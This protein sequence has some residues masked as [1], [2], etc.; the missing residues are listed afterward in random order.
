LKGLKRRVIATRSWSTVLSKLSFVRCSFDGDA[1]ERLAGFLET[2]TTNDKG[3]P[4]YDSSLKELRI[5]A[6][7]QGPLGPGL[8]SRMADAFLMKD[9]ANVGDIKTQSHSLFPTIGSQIISLS[10]THVD[11]AFLRGLIDAADRVRLRHLALTGV[12]TETGKTLSQGLPVLFSLWSLR[13]KNVM[14]EASSWILQGVALNGSIVRV[15]S[16]NMDGTCDFD[17]SQLHQIEAFGQRNK[18][19][20]MLLETE[21]GQLF[22]DAEEAVDP[23]AK[24]DVSLFPSLLACAT[25]IKCIGVTMLLSGLLTLGKY[26]C[27]ETGRHSGKSGCK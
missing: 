27:K 6:H 9:G 25:Q 21:P 14:T 10:L 16:T 26:R 1:I 8:S 22:D 15:F 13:V 20:P 11:D 12:S 24:L 2:R 4:V 3:E 17:A 5:G 23:S 7:F 18:S 19:L